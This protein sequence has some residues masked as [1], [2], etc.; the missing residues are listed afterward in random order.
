MSRG[1]KPAGQKLRIAR[2]LAAIVCW[3]ALCLLFDRIARLLRMR[4]PWPRLF[5]MGFGHLAGLRVAREGALPH[6][7]VLILA[8]HLSWLDIAALAGSCNAAFVAH[9]GLAGHPALEFLCRLN[10]TVFIAR[11][12]R[13]TVGGQVGEIA[14]AL[15]RG[16]PL[17]IFP[18]GTTNDG[19]GLLPFKS[20]LLSVAERSDA[21]VVPVALDYAEA[22]QIAW[23]G[24]DPG[25]RNFFDILA[26]REPV[27]LR[28]AILP[29]LSGDAA[30]NRKTMA[31]AARAAIATALLAEGEKPG[32][33][34]PR[35]VLSAPA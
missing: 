16:R 25:P 12:Q 20:S 30:A 2:R 14:A 15:A 10:D 3:L 17:T 5:L 23:V 24:E 28:L 34:S 35:D 33:P 21:Q 8:N 26:R 31:L 29:P 27:R 19:T 11:H 4:N 22:A 6:G 7:P 9:D 13:G 18:E 32:A 1:R